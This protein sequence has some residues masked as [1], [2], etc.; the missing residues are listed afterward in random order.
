MTDKEQRVIAKVTHSGTG[1]I[2]TLTKQ[3][4]ALGI[5]PGD[6]ISISWNDKAITIRGLAGA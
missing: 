5:K 4:R 2:V 1:M 3:L 6:S